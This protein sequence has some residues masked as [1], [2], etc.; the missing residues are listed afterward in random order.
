[1]S[2]L[3]FDFEVKKDWAWWHIFLISETGGSGFEDSQGYVEY[4]SQKKVG[5]EL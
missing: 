2:T 4:L 3:R 5:K 1:M